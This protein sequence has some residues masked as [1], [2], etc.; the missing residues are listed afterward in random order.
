MR[1]PFLAK[2]REVSY[3]IPVE[4]PVTTAT[5]WLAEGEEKE[6]EDI[7]ILVIATVLLKSAS[8]PPTT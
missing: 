2:I 4:L 1:K 7:C 5:L 3:P 8:E 6:E